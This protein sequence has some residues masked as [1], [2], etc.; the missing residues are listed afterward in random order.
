V[1]QFACRRDE[2]AESPAN[3]FESLGA[4]FHYFFCRFTQLGL[5]RLLTA[6]AAMGESE[7]MNQVQAWRAY[8]DWLQD[9]RSS[10]LEE[11]SGMER[12]FRQRYL[13]KRPARPRDRADSYL[14]AFAT[15]SEQRFQKKCH[16]AICWPV[17]LARRDRV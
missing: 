6:Q 3:W 17:C 2:D 1:A 9:D 7:V 11:P 5:F 4:D 16:R 10:I 13:D 15:A 12:V 8:D 14:G